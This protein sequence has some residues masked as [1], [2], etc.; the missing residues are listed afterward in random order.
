MTDS[1]PGAAASG[2]PSD[3]GGRPEAQFSREYTRLF[4]APL[5]HDV[6]ALRPDLI[7][8]TGP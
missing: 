8:V 3:S 7:P 5:S 1:L 4:G 6:A 2:L